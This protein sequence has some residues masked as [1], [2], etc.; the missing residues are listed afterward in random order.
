MSINTIRIDIYA[1]HRQPV[2]MGEQ[3][4]NLKE[5]LSFIGA[6]E[7]LK[8][9][10]QSS[11]SMVDPDDYDLVSIKQHL[12]YFRDVQESYNLFVIS[13]H[14]G[15]QDSPKRHASYSQLTPFLFE[16]H[17]HSQKT[18]Y[19]PKESRMCQSVDRDNFFMMKKDIHRDPLYTPSFFGVKDNPM[20][21]DDDS[22]LF[23]MSE[24]EE[25]STE[26]T[27]T[28]SPLLLKSSGIHQIFDW[29]SYITH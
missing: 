23:N 22:L 2:Y 20:R 5:F 13:P 3:D 4:D 26:Q 27:D 11:A 29:L 1:N 28:L 17:C 25:D 10:Q 14:H 24:T 21:S 15:S 18:E 12:D 6:N 19:S 9:F 8:L 7:D 16:M